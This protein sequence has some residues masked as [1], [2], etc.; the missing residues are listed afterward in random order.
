MKL[1]NLIIIF[2]IIIIPIVLIFSLYLNLETKTIMLQT[3]YDEKLIEA[4][5]EAVEAF[6]I[7]TTEWN[8]KYSSLANLKRQEIM[9]AI[10]VFTSSMSNKLGISGTSNEEILSYVPAI[11]FTM[12]DGYYIYAPTYVPET[13]TNEKG[14]QLFFYEDSGSEGAQITASATQNIGGTIVEGKPMY[15]GTEKTGTYNGEPITFTTEIVNAEKIYKHVLKTFVPYTTTYGNY[16]INYT[17]DNYIRIYGDIQSKEGYVLSE[18]E[19]ITKPDINSISEIKYNGKSIEPEILKEKI[20]VRD[21]PE[22]DAVLKEYKYIYNSNNDKRYYGDDGIFFIVNDDCIKQVLP[23]E[24]IVVGSTLAEYKKVL[25]CPNSNNNNYLELYQLINGNDNAWYYKGSNNEYIKYEGFTDSIEKY[26]DC[27]AINYYIETLSFNSWLNENRTSINI[28]EIMGKKRETIIKDINNNLNL[29]ISNYNANS[30]MDYKILELSDK[31]WDQALS[32]IS[33]ITFF[34]GAKIGLK[35]YNNYVVVTSTENNEYVSENSLYYLNSTDNY[36]HRY[37]CVMIQNE[38]VNESYRNTEFKS[39][40]YRYKKDSEEKNGYYYKHNN[41]SEDNIQQCFDCIVNRNTLTSD[42]ANTELYNKIHYTALARERYVQMSKISLIIDLDRTITV[43]FDANG[44]YCAT[45]SKEVTFNST[46]GTLPDATKHKDFA[47]WYTAREGGTEVKSA[48]VVTASEDHTLYARGKIDVILDANEGEFEDGSDRKQLVGLIQGNPYGE[49][50]TPKRDGYIFNGWEE[51][52]RG[53]LLTNNHNYNYN[54]NVP[55]VDEFAQDLEL[56]HVDK[57]ILVAQW[58]PISYIIQYHGNGSTGGNTQSSTHMYNIAKNLTENGFIKQTIDESKTW[59]HTF[60]KWNTREDGT[61]TFY[62]DKQSVINLASTNGEVIHLYAIWDGHLDINWR[63][64]GVLVYSRTDDILLANLS[65]NNIS[66]QY[67]RDFYTL[68]PYGTSWKIDGLKLQDR[69][70]P[71]S[72]DGVVGVG[73]Y[74]INIPVNTIGIKVNNSEYGTV[75]EKLLYVLEDTTYTTNK[76]VL[77]LSD[78]RQITA[79]IK[80][81][82]GYTTEFVGWSDTEGTIA[83]NTEITANFKRTEKT[84]YTIKYDANGGSGAPAAQTK[85]DGTDLTLS[86]KTPTR[87]GFIF[88]GWGTTKTAT[89]ASYQPGGKYKSNSNVTLYAIWQQVINVTSVTLNKTADQWIPLKNNNN[90]GT[91]SLNAT[92]APSNATNK[93][94]T[95]S[96]SNTSVAT[97]SN[98]TVTAKRAGLT[99]ITATAGGKTASVRVYVYNAIFKNPNS[100][101]SNY[102]MYNNSEFNVES[103]YFRFSVNAKVQVI[104]S[105]TNSDKT[106]WKLENYNVISGTFTIT[107]YEGKNGQYLNLRSTSSYVENYGAW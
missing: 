59:N 107:K 2:I 91:L 38:V 61:G 86:S 13:I 68:V 106:K 10:N 92:V 66:E 37:G 105:P 97:V 25:I 94:V 39:T 8:S 3:S 85:I 74:S 6:E 67:R 35:T 42:N 29:S 69:E 95:W 99:T 21:N 62:D 9:S 93:T 7:N 82:E 102:T 12:Y 78:G 36:Y 22:N 58:E 48:T 30:K 57:I 56:G 49:L 73:G 72:R 28:N 83:P 60:Y 44:G 32:N 33:M 17:L 81:K 43:T 87:T 34:Q 88:K 45:P 24:N 71:Y 89:S 11:V 51:N 26:E 50:E 14:V 41:Q 20:Y 53:I 103:G 84:R 31:D 5:K 27:S 96:S 23:S 18:D 75:S 80:E 19:S 100:Y 70:I 65:G 55:N 46:Y 77:T 101:V 4:T 64:N 104:I 40:S 52:I 76:N 15:K 54:Y 63:I 1:Q 90:A 79:S 98:G 16:V 47:G